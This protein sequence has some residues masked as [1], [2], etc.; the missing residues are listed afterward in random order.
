MS[1]LDELRTFVASVHRGSFAAAARYLNLSAAMVGR[2]IQSLEDRYQAKLLERTTRMH[3]LTDRGEQFLPRAEALLQAFDA[4]HDFPA[5]GEL[6]GRVRLSGPITLGTTRLPPLIARFAADHPNVK[7]E[8]T[9]SDRRVDL[10]AEDYDL[11]VRI[12]QLQASSMVSRRIGT[13]RLICCASP[14]FVARHGAPKHPSELAT[15]RCVVNL[16]LFSRSRWTFEKPSGSSVTVEVGGSVQIDNDE[17]QRAIAI[18]GGGIAYLPFDLVERD[19]AEGRLQQI[20]PGWRLPTMPIRVVYPS[21]RLMPRAVAAFV[22][23]LAES[24]EPHSRRDRK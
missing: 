23:K 2:R 16:N 18:E 3:R 13:Y 10:I 11:A 8:M 24:L 9:L 4:L 14:D 17:A 6:R 22:T 19:L 1:E 7:L 21:K 15:A 20:L 12:G 5:S